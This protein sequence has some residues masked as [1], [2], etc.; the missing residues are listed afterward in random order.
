VTAGEEATES[1]GE[2]PRTLIVTVYGAYGREVGGWIAVADLITLVGEL[3]VDEPAARSAL[4]RL[5]RRG[6]LDAKRQ[7]GAAGYALSAD[8]RQ[9]FADGDRRIFGRRT[10]TPAEGWVLAV[11]SIPES[12]R[13]RR[14]ALRSRLTWLGFGHV[15]AGVWIAPAH[16]ADEARHT[17]ERLGL[18]GYVDLF[19]ADYLAFADPPGAVAGWWDLQALKGMYDELIARYEPVL[20]RWTTADPDSGET[21]G[22]GPGS[23]PPGSTTPEVGPGGTPGGTAP[24]SGVRLSDAAAFAEHTRALTAWRRMPYLDPGLPADLLPPDWHGAR[25]AE[26][27]FRL[28][29]RLRAPAL[30]HVRTVTAGAG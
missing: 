3:G 7:S 9:V 14:H 4:S 12:E 24:G 28:H 30:R 10:A 2:T 20:A 21:P 23:G 8:A 15:A 11:F 22:A 29:A 5:K 17:L 1:R 19:R 27:F 6:I 13:Q 16:L 18:T 26:L 25:A